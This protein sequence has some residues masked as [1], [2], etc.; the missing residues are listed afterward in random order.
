MSNNSNWN[1]GASDASN[2]KGQVN[3]NSHNS[4]AAR[5]GYQAGWWS[6]K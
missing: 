5:K 3:P 2:G 1:K 4:D 6:K